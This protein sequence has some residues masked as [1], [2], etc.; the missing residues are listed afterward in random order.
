M[1]ARR[2]GL[3]VKVEPAASKISTFEQESLKPIVQQKTAARKD[4]ENLTVYP[5]TSN[6]SLDIFKDKASSVC[7][8][9]G[10]DKSAIG[11]SVRM[12]HASCQTSNETSS[13]LKDMLCSEN[14]TPEYLK[15]LAEQRR[16]ALVESLAENKELCDLVEALQAEVTRLSKYEDLVR[17]LISSV[18]EADGHVPELL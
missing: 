1:L 14:T 10:I 11:K 4:K 6:S 15:V 7:Q 9:C 3:S 8:H 2:K 17:G 5:K 12:V 13:N 18:Q 16:E